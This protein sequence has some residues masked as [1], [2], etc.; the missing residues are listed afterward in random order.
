MAP[1]AD[2]Q[3]GKPF[4]LFHADVTEFGWVV[5]CWAVTSDG[6]RFLV[7][8]SLKN[9]LRGITVTTNWQAAVGHGL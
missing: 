1:G 7:N 5:H 8:Q 6:E 2:F 9:P 3:P 4:L